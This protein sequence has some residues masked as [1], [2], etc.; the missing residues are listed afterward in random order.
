MRRYE[1]KPWDIRRCDMVHADDGEY[2]RYDDAHAKIELLTKA[3]DTVCGALAEAIKRAEKA[4][5]ER[6]EA[7]AQAEENRRLREALKKIASTGRCE[8]AEVRAVLRSTGEKE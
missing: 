8:F 5:A 2:V 3:H 7:R 6:D 1:P 4:E